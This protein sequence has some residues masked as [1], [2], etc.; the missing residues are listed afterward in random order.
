MYEVVIL[1]SFGHLDELTTILSQSCDTS[2]EIKMLSNKYNSNNMYVKK[3][4]NYLSR[5]IFLFSNL[6]GTIWKIL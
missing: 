5:F 4:N 3:V 2:N 1:V 6:D